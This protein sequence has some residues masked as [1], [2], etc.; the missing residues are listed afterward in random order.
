MIE[1]LRS[2]VSYLEEHN[3]ETLNQQF[4]KMKQAYKNAL[5][6]VDEKG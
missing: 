4:E 3:I 6:S 2:E 5:E 1:L